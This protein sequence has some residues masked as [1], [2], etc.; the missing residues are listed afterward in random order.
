MRVLHFGLILA[1]RVIVLLLQDLNI[2]Y[3]TRRFQKM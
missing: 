2:V 3:G 1:P